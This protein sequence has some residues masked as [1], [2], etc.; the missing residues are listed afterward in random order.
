MIIQQLFNGLA[1][2]MAYALIAVGYSLVFGIL[3][4]INFSHGSI[5]AFGAHF[6][7]LFI[8]MNF[9]LWPALLLSILLTGL[10]G[11]VIDKTALEPL[12]KKKSMPIAALITTI[13]V[14]YIIQNLLMIFFGSEKKAFPA[15]FDFGMIK[16]GAV[17][18]SSAQ[19]FM[20][21]VSLLLLT[22]LTVV[23][24]KTKIGLAMRATEQNAK[25]ASLMGININ[26]VVSFT[27]FLGGSSAA[28]AGALISGYYQIVYPTMG[29]MVGLKAFSAA[30]LG[31]IGILYGSVIGGLVVGLSESYAAAY[32]GGTYR[33]AVAFII[34][35]LV[36]I[37]RPAG[38]FGKKKHHKGVTMKTIDATTLE[39]PAPISPTSWLE[40][41]F[42]QYRMP[43]SLLGIAL[44]VGIPFFGLG[45][46]IMRILVMIGI[47]AILGMG[48]NLLTG[49]TGQVSL[50][51]AGFYAIGAY[52]SAIL[53]LQ[54]GV[55]FLVSC[56]SGAVVAA[57]C[58]FLL[59]L[60]TLRLTGTYL[61]I[62]TL[63]FGEIVRMVLL[64]WESV[65]NGSLGIRN[66]P[67]PKF[68]GVELTLANNGMYYLTLVFLLLISFGCYLIV[69]SKIGRAFVSIKEDEL[70]ATMMG[71]RTT[72][73][74]VL[75][76]VLSAFIS[77]IAGA[78]YAS[79]IR[80]ID[81]NSFTFDTSILI[82][83]IVIFGGMGTFR[84]VFL[85]AALLI[86]FPELLRFMMDYRF[87][88]YGLILVV[89][90]R[91]RPQ[92]LLG[93]QSQLPYRLPRG[94]LLK[95]GQAPDVTSGTRA[96]DPAM[97]EVG[98]AKTFFQAK[99]ITKRFGGLVAVDNVSFNVA[100]GEVVSLIGPNGAGKTTVFNI[101]TGVYQI[102][103]GEILFNDRHMENKMPQDIVSAGISRTF[104]NIRLF[105][106]MRVIENVLVGT[107]I[108][109]KYGFLDALFR[110][111]RFRKEE[112]EMVQHAINILESI[113][114]SHRLNDYAKNLPYG[115]QRK[116]EIAR[117]IA[118]DAQILLLDEPAAGMN[119]Q[120]SEE[121]LSFIRHLREQG[122]TIILIEHDMSVVMN[123]SDRIYVI[124]HG[125]QIAHGL[126]AEI[127]HNPNVIEAYLG[128]VQE[129]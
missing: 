124:D 30:V 78:I 122:Y 109:T 43:L 62:V 8:S 74:K 126:P 60:P 49:Y 89:M 94:V 23:I 121:L 34:L 36:L 85:G 111:P 100:K 41:L 19:L 16:L 40:R 95:S 93:W 31:G 44:L 117:A 58:G 28:I 115:E 108:R 27:F 33:D 59:G 90:M 118:T 110:T 106:N 119:P 25:A 12:R 96:A 103:E 102:R 21:L 91:F 107:H 9:G 80:F 50:G 68:F 56:L 26:F 18:F 14:S 75:A 35:I 99:A 24:K 38:L 29:F 54:F 11:I 104:Q 52:V 63:G 113:G 72:R 66:I 5:Y 47:Y 10:L 37:V 70:A 20:F 61:S 83:S 98:Q 128:G 15:F 97:P 53:S 69:N 3:R 7:L 32:L 73:Y 129:C 123:I 82:I 1:L 64:N 39:A 120:E 87:V 71:V 51:H 67:R 13:G 116:L 65:T 46:Y 45:Q 112:A 92:G 57:L 77:G 22:F 76:F 114:L 42:F 88:A 81:P 48:L 17:Q 101:L 105:P 4:L 2:G 55:H 125:K 79:M 84:G 127:A 86:S 6:A